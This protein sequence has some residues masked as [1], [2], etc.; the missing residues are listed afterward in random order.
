MLFWRCPRVSKTWYECLEQ[1]KDYSKSVSKNSW[2][3]HKPFPLGFSPLRLWTRSQPT[4]EKLA[5]MI[6][7]SNCIA[8]RYW[9]LWITCVL[10]KLTD[11]WST[12]VDMYWLLLDIFGVYVV[13]VFV[14]I[15]GN[16][17]LIYIYLHDFK[18]VRYSFRFKANTNFCSRSIYSTAIVYLSIYLI[19]AWKWEKCSV[20]CLWPNISC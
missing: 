6:A 20:T 15:F 5:M 16:P 10:F 11:V 3:R 9:L 12:C 19:A 8:E 7:S 1:I 14:N 13:F 18:S 17:V 4:H 2:R